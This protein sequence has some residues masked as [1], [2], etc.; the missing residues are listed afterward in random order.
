[1][2]TFVVAKIQNVLD[3]QADEEEKKQKSPKSLE[4]SNYHRK[5]REPVPDHLSSEKST[6]SIL[7]LGLFLLLTI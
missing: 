1:M 6:L 3:I 2:C 7:N 5:I 4:L